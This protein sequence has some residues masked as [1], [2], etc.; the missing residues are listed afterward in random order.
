VTLAIRP[1]APA[2][3]ATL[4]ELARTVW[5]AHYPPIIGEAQTEY[6]L[7]ERYAHEVIAA[8][9]ERSDVWW[10]TLRR[11]GEM[12]AFASSLLEPAREA[13]KLDKLYVHTAHQRRGSGGMLIEHAARRAADLGLRKIVLAVNKRNRTA[14]DA[15]LKH[16]FR[17]SAAVVKDI[18]GGFVMDDYVMERALPAHG[19]SREGC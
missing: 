6:M 7:A 4:I 19:A 5:R 12:I 11:D 18:G 10:D 1:L 8:E 9:L 2:E 16:G 14:I 17:I 15:Y 3:I 13:M